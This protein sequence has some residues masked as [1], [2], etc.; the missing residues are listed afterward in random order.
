[1]DIT[2]EDIRKRVV[3][4][5][6]EDPLNNVKDAVFIG[7]RNNIIYTYA[8]NGSYWDIQWRRDTPVMSV[9]FAD[10][11]CMV[12]KKIMELPPTEESPKRRSR[13]ING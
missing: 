2:L 8:D 6:N 12:C 9:L 7:V 10:I 4:G 3:L 13:R 5:K 11:P 1:M